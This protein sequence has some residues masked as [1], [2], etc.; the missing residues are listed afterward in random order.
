MAKISVIMPVYNESDMVLK[1]SIN[2]ILNQTYK[3]Y[4]FIIIN[5]ASK[6]NVKEIILSYKDSRIQYLE[7]DKNMGIVKTL[8]KALKFCNG[9]YI[10]RMDADDIAFRTRFEKQIEILD[11]YK[12]IGLVATGAITFPQKHRIQAPD[13][14]DTLKLLQACYAN[15]IIHPTVMLRKEILDNLNLEYSDEFLHVEDYFLWNELMNYTEFYTIQEPL[16]LLRKRGDSIS[17]LNMNEQIKNA[18][19]IK[20]KSIL[21]LLRIK[22]E[23]LI[24]KY[25]DYLTF[26]KISVETHLE[27]DNVYNKVIALVYN[28][29]NSYWRNFIIQELYREKKSLID[30]I[31]L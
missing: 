15:C 8:N 27:L 16:L 13:D 24:S 1:T 2:S 20:L 6:N 10:A 11:N 22:N 3:D 4:E 28:K 31:N 26:G 18:S 19:I 5:D 17:S 21:Q 30:K 14:F 23:E 25:I 7:N 9:E 12:N 29:I